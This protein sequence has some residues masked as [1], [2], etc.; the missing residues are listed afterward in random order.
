MSNINLICLFTAKSNGVLPLLFIMV[1]GTYRYLHNL[2]IFLKSIE[3][4]FAA[5]CNGVFPSSSCIIT[6]KKRISNS[7]LFFLDKI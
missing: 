6:P 4:P 7:L 5:K 1:N 3:L 2:I